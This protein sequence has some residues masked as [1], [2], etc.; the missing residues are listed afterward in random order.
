M[1]TV[2]WD[3][4][5]ILSSPYGDL[6]FNTL[7]SNGT[8]PVGYYLLDSTACMAGTARRVT[9]TNIAQAGGEITHKKYRSGYAMELTAQLWETS[10]ID[11]K[12]AEKSVL[13]EM[14]DFLMLHLN[15]LDNEDGRIRW[16][17]SGANER[18]LDR[19]RMLGPSIDGA[20][21]SV[22]VV[23]SKD[24]A[25]PLRTVTFALLSPFPYAMDYAEIDTPIADGASVALDNIGNSEF[26][27]VIKVHGPTSAFSLINNDVLGDDGEAL[28]IVYDATLPGAVPI[29][30]GHYA[31]I[32][33]F[34]NTVYLDGDGANLKPGIDILQSDFWP[35]VPGSNTITVGANIDILWQSAYA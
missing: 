11:G 15:A 8:T 5:F 3:V 17:P 6:P 34:R 13:R 32:D 20:G 19:V 12:P 9:R 25:T 18:M 28:Q 23:V 7:A 35:L 27:P 16:A 2:E 1:V 33:C 4:P 30:S 29:E 22:S 24:A 10:G 26:W 31:E 21:S 14:A